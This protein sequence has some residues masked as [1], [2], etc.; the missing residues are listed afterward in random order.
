MST[1]STSFT[2]TV[3]TTLSVTTTTLPSGGVGV[4]YSQ[5][6]NA[7][8]GVTPYSWAL[9][10]G[11]LPAGLSLSLDGLIS[12][13]PTTAAT[14][15]GLVFTVTDAGGNTAVSG[16]L[17]ITVNAS[18]LLVSTTSLPPAIVGQAYSFTLAAAN[19]SGSTTW[20]ET[21]G[22]LPTGLALSG[23]TGIISGTP[24]VATTSTGLIF[25]VTDAVPS[26]AS[27]IPLSLQVQAALTITSPSPLPS[28]T[29]GVAYSYALTAAGAVGSV[30]WA[31]TGS[32]PTGITLSPAGTLSG[33]ATTASATAP[34][35]TVTDSSGNTA[36]ATLLLSAVAA[37]PQGIP[38]L[39]IVSQ[40]Q[41]S[42]TGGYMPQPIAMSNTAG[43]ALICVVAVGSDNT[44]G[45]V[46]RSAVSDDAHNWWNLRGS[47]V[48]DTDGANVRLDVWVAEGAQ[49]CTTLNISAS[50][51]YGGIAAQVYEVANFPTQGIVDVQQTSV[52][53]VGTSTV[54]N[55]PTTK[56]DY[57]LSA[58][59]LFQ[60][61]GDQTV[62]SPGFGDQQPAMASTG[63]AAGNTSDVRV[64]SVFTSNA[65]APGTNSST[66]SWTNSANLLQV[67]LAFN[68]TPAAPT[69]PNPFM[70]GTVV[71]AA[72]GWQPGNTGNQRQPSWTDLTPRAI[73]ASGSATLA[74][75]RGRDY[76]L[77][78]PEAGSFS[79]L[80]NNMDGALN[81]GD[82]TSQ[83]AP[84]LVPEVPLRASLWW[85]GRRY[86]V[87]YAYA[88]GWPLTFPQRQWGYVQVTGKDAL[89]IASQGQMPSAYLG[90]VL[91]D[92]A[93]GYWSFM[94]Y[95]ESP[96]GA[97]F[98][99]GS[100]TNT[101][102]FVGW[103]PASLPADYVLDTGLSMN[104][105]GD[106][107]SGI[108]ISDAQS[109]DD[110]NAQSAGGGAFYNDYSLP[111]FWNTTVG[112]GST[113]EFW[114]TGADPG[115]TSDANGNASVVTLFSLLQRPWNYLNS[116]SGN[117]ANGQ[118]VTLLC[119]PATSNSVSWQLLVAQRQTQA[120]YQ[121]T[122]VFNYQSTQ[123][124]T[125]PGGVT[126]MGFECW[127]AGGAG[128]STVHGTQQGFSGG[129]GA[130]AMGTIAVSPGQTYKLTIPAGGTCSIGG[131]G[132]SPGGPTT[133]SGPVS[134]SGTPPVI[135]SAEQG[136]AHNDGGTG[137][138]AANCVFPAGGVA[139]NG[140]GSATINGSQTSGPGGGSSGGTGSNG[141]AGYPPSGNVGG[142][143]GTVSGGGS[144]GRGGSN[145]AGARDGKNGQ[146]PGGG[147]G[148]TANP[149]TGG[150]TTGGQGGGGRVRL[151]YVSPVAAGNE[152][153]IG[154]GT[155][156]PE[157]AYHVVITC[158]RQFQNTYQFTVYINGAVTIQAQV[159]Q[160]PQDFTY[161]TIAVG[162]VAYWGAPSP[163][164]NYAVG[165]VAVYDWVLPTQRI[166]NHY[167]IGLNARAY[168]NGD[169]TWLRVAGLAAW[170]QMG[171]PLGIST[172]SET[173]PVE[174]NADNVAGSALAD[175]LYN[176]AIGNGGM[177]YAPA[178]ANGEIWYEDRITQYNLLPT[179][180][181]GDNPIGLQNGNPDFNSN[182]AGWTPTGVT[183]VSTPDTT[184]PGGNSALFT[185]PAAKAYWTLAGTTSTI[186]MFGQGFANSVSTAYSS[187]VL[188]W[189]SGTAIGV[190][191]HMGMAFN[192]SLSGSYGSAVTLT[193]TPQIVW[194]NNQTAP[195]TFTANANLFFQTL[196]APGAGGQVFVQPLSTVSGATNFQ[197]LNTA[198]SSWLTP[199]TGSTTASPATVYTTVT[200][201][202]A[203]YVSPLRQGADL[204]ITGWIKDVTGT[205]AKYQISCDFL[206]ANHSYISSLSNPSA[207]FPTASW[208]FGQLVIPGSSIPSNAAY[209]RFGPTAIGSPVPPGTQFMAGQFF[210]AS[211]D[212]EIPYDPGTSFGFDDTYVYNLV[213]SARTIS[214]GSAYYTD[215]SG[216][217]TQQQYSSMGVSATLVDE[218]SETQYLPRG[219]LQQPLETTVD[220]D[221]F[222]R[223]NWSLLKYKQPF[224]RVSDLTVDLMTHP[225]HI[226]QCLT[227]E[228]GD[229]VTVIRRP[230]GFPNPI[231]L[232][233]QVQSV[234]VSVGPDT[235]TMTFKVT[236]YYPEGE[237]L[238]ADTTGY[239]TLGNMKIAW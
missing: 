153:I 97:L 120:A 8:G 53:T 90:E 114:T 16:S 197:V 69:Q 52:A 25:S 89:G 21:A 224:M 204:R 230:V 239:N 179:A 165:Q 111:Q 140:G 102:P 229:I 177:Y 27:S 38:S 152:V 147:G 176:L 198:A 210:I 47:N 54:L 199:P 116:A 77:T 34:T 59:A 66:W 231:E 184:V 83:Y 40:G 221:A 196:T 107:S 164:N 238:Q 124:I 223:A 151:T 201:A 130:Y 132:H 13:N 2:W 225:E 36:T 183:G 45:V 70:P 76:E 49:A 193:A 232:I 175:S 82:A 126:S 235:F 117:L 35:V 55:P 29:V 202:Y 64:Y 50:S 144:G 4:F 104:M 118:V 74:T 190:Q 211:D 173:D 219:P 60:S 7:S 43:N 65:V 169:P 32:W 48:N 182:L 101:K 137:G 214:N 233:V 119:S 1:A 80:L 99:N 93:Y 81:P 172:F 200:Q 154:S 84:N 42:D 186:S 23:S 158:V 19:A 15:S 192:G 208:D 75:T 109:S 171:I 10:S 37:N 222:D 30:T 123:N 228:Q 135:I 24:T 236:P 213:N 9:T 156:T 136:Y 14:T 12:G 86:G 209:A 17:S 163:V 207:F 143:G 121:T 115:D 57:L 100:R 161:E 72:F 166:Q 110:P 11:T 203:R 113:F 96:H 149:P 160:P 237:A 41:T 46:P 95:Y 216:Q 168:P 212:D 58:L 167:N 217:A 125:V 108:G 103:S 185:V 20:T 191:A 150:K 155:S 44:D 33:T 195:A 122:N 226:D 106:A 234:A 145:R 92:N 157:D 206:D 170:A 105:L 5:Q 91:Q 181:F 112:S 85:N 98:S 78:Q 51:I 71:E 128:D 205:G 131:D 189:A 28:A 139:Y 73:D 31:A 188:V 194:T 56:Y 39:S 87:G 127:G 133:I 180:T 134:G 220:Q 141:H 174:G 62:S 67:F 129:G 22:T 94:E 218:T 159:F 162:P 3:T 68:A 138:R 88:D 18:G 187:G 146:Y 215:G 26:T 61:N 227:I 178:T 63:V 6:L 142:A 148:G 79:V